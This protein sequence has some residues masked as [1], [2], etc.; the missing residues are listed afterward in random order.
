MDLLRLLAAA[1]HDLRTGDNDAR[2]LPITLCCDWLLD[3][4]GTPTSL[5]R[6]PPGVARHR[7]RRGRLTVVGRRAHVLSLDDTH[8]PRGAHRA[9]WAAIVRT[10]GRCTRR[11]G[12][13]VSPFGPR[14]RLGPSFRWT[15]G[16]SRR[17]SGHGILSSLGTLRA[18]SP[19][20][21]LR[22][23]LSRFQRRGPGL[24]LH[25]DGGLGRP[26]GPRL[27]RRLDRWLAR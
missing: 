1:A 22:R 12:A 15:R 24:G 11:S 3:T 17:S 7:R 19:S 10:L 16:G 18:L 4:V 8:G 25:L 5:G 23:R 20:L 9:L 26:L 27:A 6:R 14:R 2:P 13:L 21:S